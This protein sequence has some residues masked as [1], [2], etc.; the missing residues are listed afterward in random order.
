[1]RDISGLMGGI[2]LIAEWFMRFTIVNILWFIINLPITI[3]VLSSLFNDSRSAMIMHMVPALLLFPILLF[4]STVAL[5]GVTRDWLL[6]KD[7]TSL[8]KTYF[9]Y[10]KDSYKT[11]LLSGAGW[12]I[13]WLIWIMDLYF[14]SKENDLLTI[15]FMIIGLLLFVMN[16]NFFSLTAHYRMCL[17]DLFK[18]SFFLTFGR[19]LL[20][21]IILILNILIIYISTKVWFL[22]PFF[23]G[24]IS[25]FLS[26]YAFYKFT[27]KVEK[28]SAV[29]NM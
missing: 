19:P 26:F 20:S 22:L 4:P 17:R 7:Q 6:E 5:F 23:S 14:F 9:S 16:M 1:M 11:A 15:I 21:F 10:F 12:G 24:T 28:K 27:L 3:I 29:Q 8:I 13:I 25:V 2:H 18:N